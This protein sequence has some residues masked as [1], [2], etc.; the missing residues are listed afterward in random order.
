MKLD[1]TTLKKKTLELT[2]LDKTIVEIK[3]PSKEFLIELENFK[4]ETANL[5]LVKSFDLMEEMTLK[6]LNN[7]A[8][9]KVYD[10][11]YL[12]DTKI[13]YSVQMIIF[14][15]YFEFVQD[16]LYNPN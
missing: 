8:A 15:T 2:L 6:I 12:E 5:T 7:N 16:A 4:E 3:K 10:K 9:G 13:D 14:N 1:L 11:N